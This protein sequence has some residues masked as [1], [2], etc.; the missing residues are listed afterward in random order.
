MVKKTK[1]TRNLPNISVVI[2]MRNSQTTIIETLESIRK[3]TYPVQEIIV[4]DDM[5]T[6]ASYALVKKYSNVHKQ[7]HISMIKNKT[8][9]MIARSQDKAVKLS[10]YD[11]IVFTHSDCR[12]SSTRDIEKLIQPII[13][14]PSIIATYGG[15]EN[16]I[17]IWMQ[18]SFWEK[19]LLCHDS[20][21]LQKVGL[22]GKVDCIQ[23]KAFLSIGGHDIEG[24]DNYGGEDAD[25]HLR[26][27]KKG[28]IVPTDAKAEHLQIADSGYPISRLFWKTKF[29]GDEYG[30][31]LRVEKLK[32]GFSPF[33]Y[34]FVK[35][36]LAIGSLIPQV[37]ILF[38][39]L[40]LLFIFFYYQR[41]FTTRLTLTDP[42]IFLLPFVGIALVYYQTFW[43]F[44]TFFKPIHRRKI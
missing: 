13:K 27:Q 38:I 8:H 9:L 36:V 33:S 12:F 2:P 14:D 43:T 1:K 42:K 7:M 23:K 39:P 35:P 30:R 5:S 31:L 3:Q 19:M 18:Y 28:K 26:L 34:I 20:G 32:Y 21:K 44:V 29:Y 11:Y 6:D 25:L 17:S 16:P 10:K 41:M 22:L 24:F 4:V 40:L 15:T 37:N